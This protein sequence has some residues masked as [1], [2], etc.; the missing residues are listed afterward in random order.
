MRK[1]SKFTQKMVQ[2]GI[3]KYIVYVYIPFTFTSPKKT[4]YT[5]PKG[6]STSPPLGVARQPFNTDSG[7][8]SERPAYAAPAKLTWHGSKMDP[9]F[10]LNTIKMVSVDLSIGLCKNSWLENWLDGSDEFRFGAWLIFKGYG[11]VSFRGV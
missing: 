1:H 9:S 8:F 4:P 6:T 5:F 7:T 3:Y 2:L 10:L 11:Y